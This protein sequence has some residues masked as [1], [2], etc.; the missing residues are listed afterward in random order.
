VARAF[1]SATVYVHEKGARHL[2]DP[3]RL[4]DS[5]ARVYGPLLD[6]LYG[7]MDPTDAARLHVVA[8]GEEIAVGPSRTLVAVDSPGHAKHHV[9]FHDSESGVLF[10]GD[11]VGVRLPD[12][13]VLRPATPPP[14]FDL[15][16]ALNSL[17][18]FAARRPSGLALAHYGLLESPEEL[19]A[20]ADDT[21]RQW[22]ETAETAFRAGTDIAEAL[23]ARFDVSLRGVDPIHRE[24]LETLNGVHSNA[25][26]FRRWLEGREPAN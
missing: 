3:S 10:A 14:D 16:L 21:L 8:D 24:K 20:E 7:R 6:S 11:A 4:I 9:G 13:G 1:P 23:S 19:L 26:G 15:A 22:A 12:A 2:A 5:A 18:K 25:A 17:Q